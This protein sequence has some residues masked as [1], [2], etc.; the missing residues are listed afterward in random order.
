MAHK[1]QPESILA[2]LRL[3]EG[4]NWQRSGIAGESIGV[5]TMVKGDHFPSAP[6]AEFAGE[7]CA[8]RNRKV[9]APYRLA[10][11]RSLDQ[12]VGPDRVIAA[13]ANITDKICGSVKRVTR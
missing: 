3:S 6:I 9:C 2:I 5:K 11:Q 8:W 13:G 10:G 12:G 7:G 4:I 1:K